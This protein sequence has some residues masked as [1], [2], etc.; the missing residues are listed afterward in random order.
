MSPR[1]ENAATRAH[2]DEPLGHQLMVRRNHHPMIDGEIRR[3]LRVLG[4][5]G[6]PA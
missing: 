4:S 5:R 3:E 6:S 2:L 1:K